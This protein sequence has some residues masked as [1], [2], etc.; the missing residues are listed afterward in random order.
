[1]TEFKQHISAHKVPAK[2]MIGSLSPDIILGMGPN[3]ERR[4]YN[5]TS[6]LIGWAHNQNKPGSRRSNKL[7][8]KQHTVLR[9]GMANM[10]TS[11][12][13]NIFSALLALCAG[14]VTGEFP[15]QRPVTRSFD[16]FF[17][18]CRNKRLNKQS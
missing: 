3:N 10:M 18:L 5:V 9:M 1:M 7:F 12:N 6:S 2:Q 4:R 13:G 8:C 14:N 11:S 16:V 15:L 17:H